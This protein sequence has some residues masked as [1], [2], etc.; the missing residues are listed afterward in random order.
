MRINSLLQQGEY[1]I[2]LKME[3]QKEEKVYSLSDNFVSMRL[4]VQ[5]KS[6]IKMM[7]YCIVVDVSITNYRSNWTQM[8]HRTYT[9]YSI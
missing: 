4:D 3:S 9:L 8:V 7:N 6:L 2:L 5:S 1:P